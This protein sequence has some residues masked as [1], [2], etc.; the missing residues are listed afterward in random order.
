LKKDRNT[1]ADVV[2]DRLAAG[3]RWIASLCSVQAAV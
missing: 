2:L 3:S 1:P